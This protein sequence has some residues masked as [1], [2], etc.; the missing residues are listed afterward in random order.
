MTEAMNK[1]ER[2]LASARAEHERY[3]EV[4]LPTARAQAVE[5]YLQSE[6]FKA[7]LVTEYQEGM[8]DMKAGFIANNPSLVGVD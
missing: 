5:E 3:L 8:R 7:R 1:A 4:A 2:D 6:D